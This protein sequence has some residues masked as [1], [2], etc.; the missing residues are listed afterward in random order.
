MYIYRYIYLT[1]AAI[2]PTFDAEK[3]SKRR[4]I[5]TGS[6]GLLGNRMFWLFIVGLFC[7]SC[8]ICMLTLLLMPLAGLH[9]CVGL[10][11]VTP[12]LQSFFQ[13]NIIIIIR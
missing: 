12:W 11:F 5:S 9:F 4:K 1:A 13:V 8:I 2:T 3:K 10:D 7:L 6:S